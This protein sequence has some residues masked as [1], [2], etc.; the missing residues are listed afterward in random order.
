MDN[1]V[2]FIELRI[3]FTQT[4]PIDN[5]VVRNYKYAKWVKATNQNFRR[6]Y[7]KHY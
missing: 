7:A 4:H 1:P 5:A 2:T 6:Y 3:M